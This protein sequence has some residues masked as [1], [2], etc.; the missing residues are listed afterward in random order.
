MADGRCFNHLAAIILLADPLSSSQTSVIFTG[1]AYQ[2]LKPQICGR[3]LDYSIRTLTAH[4]RGIW[5]QW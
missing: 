5:L 2:G 4:A 3:V 1:G